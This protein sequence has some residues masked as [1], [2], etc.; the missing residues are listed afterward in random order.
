MEHGL[1]QR[2]RR[3]DLS[4]KSIRRSSDLIAINKQKTIIAIDLCFSKNCRTIVC[5]P[6]TNNN[7]ESNGET[8]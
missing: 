6:M 3:E 2:N 7:I 5:T 4:L 8:W 1:Y